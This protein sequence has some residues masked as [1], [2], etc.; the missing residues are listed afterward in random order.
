MAA[1]TAS[2]PNRPSSQ[3]ITALQYNEESATGCSIAYVHGVNT[4]QAGLT[5][6]PFYVI[7][8]QILALQ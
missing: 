4:A 1:A 3:G 5:H 8:P 7:C 6:V 2:D